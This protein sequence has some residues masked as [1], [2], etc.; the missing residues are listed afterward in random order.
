MDPILFL[1]TIYKFYCQLIFIFI[2]MWEI[3][4][5]YLLSHHIFY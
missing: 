2:Y 3:L 4:N 1:G 5:K